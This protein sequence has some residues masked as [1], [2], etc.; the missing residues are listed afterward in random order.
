MKR[1][2]NPV[3]RPPTTR[4]PYPQTPERAHA[5]IKAH[6]IAVADLARWNN[7]PRLV[8]VDL[9]RG[10]LRGHRG[11]AHRAAIVLGLKP[12]PEPMA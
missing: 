1:R 3:A 11:Q 8:L 10:R 5:W 9:L 4:V 2:N 6:G 7:L 12:D